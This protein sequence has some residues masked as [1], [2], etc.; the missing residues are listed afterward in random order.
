M[1]FQVYKVHNAPGESRA[2]LEQVE[3]KYGFVPNLIGVLAESPAA[4][5]AYVSASLAFEKSSFNPVEQQVVL[6]SAS[7][8]NRCEYCVAAHSMVAKMIGAPNALLEAV[9]SGTPLSDRRL[10]ALRRFTRAVVQKRGWVS[11]Q[12]VEGFRREGFTARHVLEVLVGVA[13]KTLSNYSNHIPHTPVDEAF[14][15]YAWKSPENVSA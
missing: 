3:R 13:L 5:E 12:D 11:A 1:D 4:L 9:R 6:L 8:E 10:E 15:E 7:L 2:T 14:R